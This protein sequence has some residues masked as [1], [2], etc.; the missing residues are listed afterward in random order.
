MSTLV[1]RVQHYAYIRSVDNRY[2]P[3]WERT[4]AREADGRRAAE[5]WMRASEGFNGLWLDGD[6]RLH[7]ENTR[8]LSFY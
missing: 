3:E 6:L 7:D 4:T 1:A 2:L 8:A 5:K